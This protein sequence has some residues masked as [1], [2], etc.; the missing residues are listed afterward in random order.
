MRASA[1]TQRRWRA[2]IV[3]TLPVLII[4]MDATTL[5]FAIPQLSEAL[6]PTSS[7]LLWIIDI[8]SFVLAGLLITMGALGDR[9][10]RRRLL[11]AGAIAFSAASLL[12]A[13]STDAITALPMPAVA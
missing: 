6:Q 7:Q 4:S 1:E 11:I 3:L 10:G 12:A 9:I 13:F 5:G 8:Y 2:L